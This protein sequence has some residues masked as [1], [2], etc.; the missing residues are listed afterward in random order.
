MI[1]NIPDFPTAFVAAAFRSSTPEGWLLL[2]GQTIGNQFSG[3]SAR[4]SADTEALFLT[5]WNDTIA[6]VVGGRGDSAAADYAANKELV[7]PNAG[8]RVLAGS[9]P[10]GSI[11]SD[12]TILGVEKGEQSSHLSMAQVPQHQHNIGGTQTFDT[13]GDGSTVVGVTGTETGTATGELVSAQ[14]HNNVQP[15]LIVNW[16]I[17]L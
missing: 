2:N 16:M 13:N 5:L 7:L 9:D 12:A 14:V 11:L 6:D 1:I 17:K 10:A 3:A 4:A 15:T 8:G